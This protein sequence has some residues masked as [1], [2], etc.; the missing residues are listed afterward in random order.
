MTTLYP[1]Q[2]SRAG[3]PP[4][5]NDQAVIPYFNDTILDTPVGARLSTS[6]VTRRTKGNTAQGLG[7]GI[8][9]PYGLYY[10]NDNGD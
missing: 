6:Y 7:I 4:G 2:L 1:L 5:T 8:Y 3:D 10:A 9:L